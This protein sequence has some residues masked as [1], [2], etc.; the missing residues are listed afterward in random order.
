[1]ERMCSPEQPFFL[2]EDKRALP[3]LGH[4][5]S[6]AAQ[7]LQMD[8]DLHQFPSQEGMHLGLG[9]VCRR[10]EVFWQRILQG[11]AHRGPRFGD[12]WLGRCDLDRAAQI[13]FICAGEGGMHERLSFGRTG[14]LRQLKHTLAHNLG[15]RKLKDAMWFDGAQGFDNH[16]PPFNKT[17]AG[18]SAGVTF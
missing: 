13:V 9:A 12:D 18:I 16:T 10:S 14:R 8:A 11:C 4:L 2:L 1:M 3:L 5:R 17:V 15:H 6:L 7:H